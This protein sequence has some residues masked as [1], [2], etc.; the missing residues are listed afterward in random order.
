MKVKIIAVGKNKHSYI[1]EGIKFYS[2][3]LNDINIIEV[4]DEKQSDGMKKEAD[5]IIE[6]IGLDEYVVLLAIDGQQLSSESFA[7]KLNHIQ[8]YESSK[9][10]FVIGGSYG[11]TNDVI[12]RANYKL[13]FSKMTFPHLLMRLILIEQIYRA[14]MIL[15]NH[16][17]HK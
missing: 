7:E 11:V 13:S 17:Y 10:T 14:K 12:K 15:Q 2:K 3:Q 5:R 4:A 1:E 9:I 6:Q 8:T 16:P